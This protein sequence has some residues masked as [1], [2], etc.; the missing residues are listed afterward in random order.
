MYTNVSERGRNSSGVVVNSTVKPTGT[1]STSLVT[2]FR[3]RC[4]TGDGYIWKY[5]YTV[6]ASDTIK[7]VTNDFI[8][9]KTLVLKQKL[10]VLQVHYGSAAT[11][12][13]SSQ[14]RC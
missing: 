9:V 6:S 14:W 8:P 1:V 4:S 7:F 11:D 3:Y 10:M 12:D 13:G 5:M 2:D